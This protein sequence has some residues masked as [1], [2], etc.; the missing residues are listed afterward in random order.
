[1]L[2]CFQASLSFNASGRTTV[3]S[4]DLTLVMVPQ[5]PSARVALPTSFPTPLIG[6]TLPAA[7]SQMDDKLYL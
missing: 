7:A 1:M 2:V 4:P 5:S 6:L 3:S